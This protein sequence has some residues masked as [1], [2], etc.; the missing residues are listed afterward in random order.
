MRLPNFVTLSIGALL[1]ASLSGCVTDAPPQPQPSATFVAPYA[2]DEEALAAAEAAFAQYLRV[3]DTVLNAGGFDPD[4][5]SAVAVGPF[6]E[7]SIESFDEQQEAGHA[8]SGY[9]S[10]ASIELQRY[11]PG[12]PSSEII[13]AYVC[14]D[15]TQVDVVD[16]NG[17]SVVAA[18][19]NDT[20]L[21]QATFDFVEE[22]NG[23]KVSGVEKWQDEP[24]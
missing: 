2:S 14:E 13:T 24:C 17:D 6:L 8:G 9:S 5:L 18:D 1:V 21:F 15:L 20:I 11:S 10:I 23:L 19:R 3:A 7:K 4:P 12:G 16:Q 22:S